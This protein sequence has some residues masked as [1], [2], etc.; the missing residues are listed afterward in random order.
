VNQ[1]KSERTLLSE[2]L[3][4]VLMTSY[5]REKYIAEAIESVLASSWRNFELIIVDDQS[6]DD[7][8]SIAKSY[9]KNDERVKVY[10]NETNLRDYPNRNKA[11]SYAKGKYLKYVDSDDKIYDWGLAYCVEQM[12]KYPQ[13]SFGVSMIDGDYSLPAVLMN[14]EDVI[15]KHLFQSTHLSAGPTGTIIQRKFF[16]DIQGFDTRFFMAN[17][18]Y[19]NVKVAAL[20]PVVLLKKPFF[21]YRLHDSQEQNNRMGYLTYGFLA[22]KEIIERLNIPL[23]KDEIRY[24]AKKWN[25]EHATELI[26]L[27]LVHKK[28]SEAYRIMKMTSFGFV[29]LIKGIFEK[30]KSSFYR[31]A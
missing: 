8:F 28:I 2:P 25:K 20:T 15:R 23:T 19:F 9:E 21:F 29:D 22:K 10:K 26:K 4:S 12:E 16:E 6:T 13:S 11:A 24:L 27:I 7:T 3:V 14:S 18:E 17:D 1:L 30:S 31:K 5:N